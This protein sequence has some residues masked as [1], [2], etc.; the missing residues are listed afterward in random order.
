MKP[1]INVGDVAVITF[2][3]D[4]A[5]IEKDD[6]IAFQSS[7][8]GETVIHRVMDVTPEGYLTK[9]DANEGVDLEPVSSDKVL[10]IYHFKIPF[11]GFFFEGI[12]HV[13]QW[14]F[15]ES[16]M[17]LVLIGIFSTIFFFSFKRKIPVSLIDKQQN[18]EE[19]K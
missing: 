18:E 5:K 16:R 7:K 14:M 9:G 8:L 17:G 4:N 19:R 6:V 12:K 3:S 2:A 11:L 15:Y 13:T 10:G 1:A